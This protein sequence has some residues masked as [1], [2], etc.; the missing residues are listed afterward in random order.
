MSSSLLNVSNDVSSRPEG[1]SL[2][3]VEVFIDSEEQNWLKRAHVGRFSELEDIQTSLNGLE[4]CEMLTG[5]ELVPSR[6]GTP[7]WSEPKD[8]QN[9]T[10]KLLSLLGV[11][12]VIVNSR[13]DKGKVLKEPILKDIIPRGLDARIKEI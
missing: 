9:K 12:Y 8:Q 7:D 2:K 5:Q 10:D 13:K 1:L 6:H 3:N 4:K 11:M